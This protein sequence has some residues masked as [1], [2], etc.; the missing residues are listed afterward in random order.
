MKIFSLLFALALAQTAFAQTVNL[1][2]DDSPDISTVTNANY[3]VYIVG[4]S[5]AEANV[6]RATT[7]SVSNL[8]AGV[9]YEFFV[10]LVDDRGIESEPSNIA[11]YTVATGL[12]AVPKFAS[13]TV[14]G[15]GNTTWRFVV[16]VQAPPTNQVVTNILVIFRQSPSFSLTN[17][18]GT[19]LTT[20]ALV[21]AKN[22][23]IHLQAQN[24][25]G[26]S[27]VGY[28]ESVNK[29]NGPERLRAFQL[30]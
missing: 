2:W 25:V 12:P 30:P 14:T 23:L 27:P 3:R 22:T 11:S 28:V 10:V 29:K 4:K 18:L 16:N 26:W 20:T 13:Y 9:T 7:A 24:A 5:V 1:A 17:I 8:V 21:P 6:G 15:Q 19:N